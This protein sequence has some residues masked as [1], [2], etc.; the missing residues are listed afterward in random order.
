M[1]SILD[2]EEAK[3][4]RLDSR[5]Y[6]E[7]VDAFFNPGRKDDMIM[8]VAFEKESSIPV[9]MALLKKNV[10]DPN[11]LRPLPGHS[12]G[13]EM[14]TTNRKLYW[15]LSFCVRKADQ[16]SKCLGDI[17]LSC[18]I[19]EVYHRAENHPST[20]IWLIVAGGFANTPALRLYLAYGFVFTGMYETSV[21]M[22]LCNIGQESVRKA[23]KQVT[24]MLESKFLLPVLRQTVDAQQKA[25][26]SSELNSQQSVQIASTS[27]EPNTPE[28]SS[29]GTQDP[30]SQDSTRVGGSVNGYS[31]SQHSKVAGSQEGD[32]SEVSAVKIKKNVNSQI[33]YA[34]FIS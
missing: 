7:A 23:L 13:A 30:A 4:N 14:K 17:C 11:K 19:E 8:I 1:K 27:S 18:A 34:H 31:V 2:A 24:S 20:Y 25:M 33:K 26:T 15:E 9:A 10:Y 12:I 32:Y 5:A 28:P 3:T 6:R 21:M 29:Q 16:R 22:A